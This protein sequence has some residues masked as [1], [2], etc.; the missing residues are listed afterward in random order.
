MLVDTLAV[1]LRPRTP[2]EAI[3]LGVRLC[4]SAA[5]SV[6]RCY[7]VALLPVIA[8]AVAS[9]EVIGSAASLVI[10]WLK[11]WL[12]RTILFVLSRAAFGQDTTIGDLWRAQWRVWWRPLLFTLTVRRLSPWRSL[13]EPVYLLEDGPA[14]GSG[15]RIVQIRNRVV[16]SAFMMTQTFVLA[17]LA[18]SLGLFSLFFWFAPAGVDADPLMFFADETPTA[19]AIA[20]FT[21]YSVAVFLLEPFYVAAG[22]AMYL[23]R[24]AELEAWDIE[25]EFRHA[26]APGVQLVAGLLLVVLLAATPAAAQEAAP[27]API[28]QAEITAAVEA[29][30]RDPNLGGERT[31]KMLQWRQTQ[32][33]SKRDLGWL[34]W[35]AGFFGWFMQ[36]ARYLMWAAIV[37]LAA[38][39]AIYLLRAFR[40]RQADAPDAF[41]PPTHVR[42]LDIRPESLPAN[43]GAAARALWDRG[44]HRAALS[45]L[46]R[47]LLSRLTHVHRVPIRDSSTEGDCLL[48]LAGRVPPKTGEYSERLVDAWRG[49]VYGGTEA[50]APAIHAL[51]DNF[52]GALDRAMPRPIEGG[53]E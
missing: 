53:A 4:Q 8:L 33:P 17:E 48:L 10:W 31:M 37:F 21:A 18:I 45:L 42:N 11:P 2:N 7:L 38:W 52:A 25:Q 16:G 5:P 39:L 13:T 14:I 27:A 6:Y 41:V 30:K 51:C 34:S 24:R 22:F 1:R 47:G 29:V 36:S 28:T 3:D 9:T 50:P 40:L 26:F 20:Y 49:F 32:Q 44:E 43:I 12:D 15:A 35:I 23:N 19:M 46:Y